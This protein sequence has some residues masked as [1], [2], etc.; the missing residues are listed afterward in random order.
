MAV[1]PKVAMQDF[2]WISKKTEF[3]ILRLL[4]SAVTAEKLQIPD[5][6]EPPKDKSGLLAVPPYRS[7]K[8]FSLDTT[9]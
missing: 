2:G 9:S 1:L 5:F 8:T 4:P 3:G 7:V 6:R